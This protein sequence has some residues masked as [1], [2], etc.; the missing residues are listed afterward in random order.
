[1]VTFRMEV[2]WQVTWWVLIWTSTFTFPSKALLYHIDNVTNLSK[3][4]L[5]PRKNVCDSEDVFPLTDIY[6]IQTI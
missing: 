6:A 4:M 5:L 1:M 2:T 3:K